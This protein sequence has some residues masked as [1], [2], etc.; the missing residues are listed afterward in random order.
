[1]KEFA[2]GFCLYNPDESFYYRLNLLRNAGIVTFI[3]D[4]SKVSYFNVNNYSNNYGFH[5][6]PLNSGLGYGLH[7]ILK[8]AFQKKKTFL[9]DSK[10]SES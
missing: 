10:L 3:Y 2:L 4:N 1:M 9:N 8:E 5:H 6:D 7:W